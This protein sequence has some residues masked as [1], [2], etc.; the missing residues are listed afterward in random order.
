MRNAELTDIESIMMLEKGAIDHPWQEDAIRALIENPCKLALVETADN[1][2]LTGYIGCEWV[3]DEANI[4][5]LAVRPDSRRRGIARRL[6]NELEIRLKEEGITVIF[7][8]VRYDNEPAV[9]LYESSGYEVYNRRR[10]YY[11]EGKDALLMKK[12]I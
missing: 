5:N 3:I 10:D 7:L 4:G 12:L 9:S 8:E 6:L 2:D 1:G 11:G